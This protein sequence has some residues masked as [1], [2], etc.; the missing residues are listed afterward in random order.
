MYNAEV[1]LLTLQVDY[2]KTAHHFLIKRRRPFWVPKDRVFWSM[3]LCRVKFKL[4]AIRE[5]IRISLYCDWVA[6]LR[7]KLSWNSTC[8]CLS[9]YVGIIVFISKGQI[10]IPHSVDYDI[11]AENQR[12][13]L[14]RILRLRCKATLVFLYR[15]HVHSTYFL[16]RTTS[17][18]EMFLFHIF[19]ILITTFFRP[20]YFPRVIAKLPIA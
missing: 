15:V 6:Y 9:W 13:I 17:L 1:L 20:S 11:A 12:V 8:L 16:E 7:T 2:W 10:R 18:I 19:K 5:Y 4:T 3:L 14:F